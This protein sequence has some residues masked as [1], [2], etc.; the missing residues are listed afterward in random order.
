MAVENVLSLAGFHQPRRLVMSLDPELQ[1]LLLLMFG[2]LLLGGLLGFSSM[3][4]RR[5]KTGKWLP[6]RP[7]AEAS[8]SAD[9]AAA[10][11]Q[12]AWLT[13]PWIPYAGILLFGALSVMSFLN[14]SPY[15]GG[16]F[17]LIALVYVGL[18]IKFRK[19]AK[20]A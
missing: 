19:Q 11:V 14:A 1:Q 12:P 9:P 5:L 16:V 20:S 4:M 7:V 18:A 17:A 6:E 10:P 8:E 13:S 3:A 15:Y 2:S